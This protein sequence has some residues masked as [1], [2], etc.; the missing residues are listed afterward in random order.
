MN[1]APGLP[2]LS[3]FVVVARVVRT[4][5]TPASDG[6]YMGGVILLLFRGPVGA[7]KLNGVP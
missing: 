1:G 4:G 2:F 7:N 3:S 6:D 5:L